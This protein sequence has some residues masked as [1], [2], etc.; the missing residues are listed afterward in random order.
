MELILVLPLVTLEPSL[1]FPFFT[2]PQNGKR[3]LDSRLHD[4]ILKSIANCYEGTTRNMSVHPSDV[5]LVLLLCH[6]HSYLH[7]SSSD[8]RGCYHVLQHVTLEYLRLTVPH[9]VTFSINSLMP[10]LYNMT[11]LRSGKRVHVVLGL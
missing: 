3:R 2:C 11:F 10:K 6:H 8:H 9:V 1:F 5:P 4:P 7:C